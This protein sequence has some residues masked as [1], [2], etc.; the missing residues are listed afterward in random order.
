M[1]QYRQQQ[2]EKMLAAITGAGYSGMSRRQFAELLNIKKGKHLNGLIDELIARKL[3]RKVDG[4]DNHN[5][6][7]FIYVVVSI[8][9][10]EYDVQ[11]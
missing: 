2:C 3:A 7:L 11:S 5:R 9:Q 4:V 8:S 1:S 6:P 10:A